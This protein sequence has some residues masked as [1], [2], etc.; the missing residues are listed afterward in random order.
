MRSGS[1][2]TITP[3]AG[4]SRREML[5][6][7]G[8]AALGGAAA[9]AL[10]A[11][12]GKDA[13]GG[14]SEE[15]QFMFWGSTLEQK[16]INA[17]LAEFK[18]HA[19]AAG[20]NVQP[21]YT[22]GPEYNTKLNTLVASKRAPDL[23]YL[24]GGA[25]YRLAEQGKLINLYP[26]LKKYP[27]LADRLPYT[28]YWYGKN[29][30][31]GTQTA[32]EVMLLWYN[33]QAFDEAGVDYPPAEADKAWTWDQLLEASYKLTVD[34]EGRHP[35]EPDFDAKAVRQ[36]GI[37][38]NWNSFGWY[39][40][41]AS[42]GGEAVDETGKNFVLNGEAGVQV[43]QNLQ[44]L[45]YK[46]RVAPT[47]AQLATGGAAV[48]TTPR[49]LQTRRIG[50]AIDGQWLL[51]DMAQSD[52]DYGI[53]VL[54]KYQE[55]LTVGFAAGTIAFT[56]NGRDDEAVELYMFHNDPRYVDL[57]KSG[58]WMPLENKYYTDPAA[59]DSWTDNDSHPPE[60][61]TAVLD[62]TLNHS[63]RQYDQNLKNSDNIGEI[64]TPALQQI[65]NGKKSAKE[66]LDALKPNIDKLLQGYYP[67][68][69]LA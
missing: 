24:G 41:V 3:S 2:T 67:T 62:Y 26:Y 50:M 9:P 68:Q 1:G 19:K 55:P 4:W 20:G 59:I 63:V 15:L 14:E 23:A 60:F 39:P 5:R 18:D 31:A 38:P 61:R 53:A 33:K 44:D 32:N 21:L 52:L 10:A 13:G 54:P 56:G 65:Q 48:P 28:Y 47:P 69:E 30:L 8:L 58:L 46:H 35:D 7:G 36:F 22:P 64:M 34:Q 16:A 49:L 43:L 57:Y 11:C 29:K 6:L 37:A 17:M 42:N 66:V 45:T 27:E 51:L 40:L 25:L 12:A